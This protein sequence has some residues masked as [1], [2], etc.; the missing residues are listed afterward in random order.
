M[1]GWK[2][3]LLSLLL[4]ALPLL[5]HAEGEQ[6]PIPDP[7]E[8]I[9]Y[10][11]A[12]FDR[13]ALF[14]PNAEQLRQGEK[15][16]F[17]QALQRALEWNPKLRSAE[18]QVQ[19]GIALILQGALVPNPNL[20]ISPS[21]ILGS[22]PFQSFDAVELDILLTVTVELAGK[23]RSRIE[24]ASANA[25]LNKYTWIGTA[26]DV[27]RNT[28]K[29]YIELLV[30]QKLAP[31][32]R[33]LY[34]S[35]L[36]MVQLNSATPEQTDGRSD[37]VD[38]NED[39]AMQRVRAEVIALQNRVRYESAL[40]RLAQAKQALA[41]NW[42]AI[43]PDFGVAEGKLDPIPTPVQMDEVLPLMANNPDIQRWE[44]MR[45]L[46]QANL[47]QQ[48][49][50]A[51]PNLILGAEFEGNRIPLSYSWLFSAA[52]D[53]PV[54]NRN[55][56]NIRKSLFAIQQ[57]EEDYR[58]AYT[59]IGQQLEIAQQQLAV[60]S[61][62]ATMLSQQGILKARIAFEG[63]K[64][65]FKEGTVRYSTFVNAQDTLSQA[66]VDALEALGRAHKARADLDRLIGVCAGKIH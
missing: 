58:Y 35:S 3:Y 13:E 47:R 29:A 63:A 27:C 66:E 16:T 65:G 25:Q 60:A 45:W 14:L 36:H 52:I 2:L 8:L 38:S 49:A 12:A 39:L 18:W 26:L 48:R 34:A 23:R 6:D 22:E 24:V 53:I 31:I 1:K 41:A 20:Y 55:Q 15:I 62:V 11:E 64:S 56:G 7:D 19:E 9:Q 61:L 21:Q 17:A 30:A 42:G 32:Q 51:V 28:T 54:C 59:Q 37:H 40:M 4:T 43:E 50:L 33:Y 10:A 46:A 5:L 44:T 57:T